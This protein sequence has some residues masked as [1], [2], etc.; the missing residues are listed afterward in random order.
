MGCRVARYPG[1]LNRGDLTVAEQFDINGITG[2]NH[3]ESA[4]R[5]EQITAVRASVEYIPHC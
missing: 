5:S 2:Y 3:L 4:P 1:C